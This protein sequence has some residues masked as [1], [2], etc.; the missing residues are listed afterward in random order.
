M[1]PTRAIY[2]GGAGDIVVVWPDGS[3]STHV[4][5]PAGTVLPVRAKRVNST[6]KADHAD[7]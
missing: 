4:G 5:V 6:G 7:R 2:V 3:T 1:R